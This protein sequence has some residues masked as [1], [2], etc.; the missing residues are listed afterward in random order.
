MDVGEVSV[1]GAGE[2]VSAVSQSHVVD[3]VE[4]GNDHV[5]ALAQGGGGVGQSLSVVVVSLGSPSDGSALVAEDVGFSRGS[6]GLI[7]G[8][9]AVSGVSSDVDAVGGRVN[10]GQGEVLTAATVAVEVFDDLV[11]ENVDVLEKISD[12]SRTVLLSVNGEVLHV[13]EDE[14]AAGVTNTQEIGGVS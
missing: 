11:P 3:I 5:E 1:V 13:A 6:T 9:E 14:V 8:Q 4:G 7:K 12:V 10:G 2:T